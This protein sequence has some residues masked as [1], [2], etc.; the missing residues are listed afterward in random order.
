MDNKAKKQREEI[1]II[2]IGLK[3]SWARDLDQYWEIINNKICCTEDF[4]KYR[5]K[6]VEGLVNIFYKGDNNPRFYQG[7]YIGRI[8]EFDNEFFH[9]SP[10]EASLMDPVQRIFLETIRNT[11]D[12]AGYTATQLKQSKTGVFL[13]YT[14]SSLKDNYIVDIALNHRDLLAYSMTGNMA[15]LIPSRISHLLDLK[16]PTMVMDTAC[17]SAL[18]AVHEACEHILSGNCEMAV[19]GGIK[20]NVMPLILDDMSIGIESL[21]GKTRTFDRGA[22][23]SSMGEGCCTILLKPLHKAKEDGDIIYSIIKSSS[24]NHDG[25]ASG[26]TAPNPTAQS[27][28]MID[29]WNKANINPEDLQY[30]EAHGTATGLGD[31]IEIQGINKAFGKFTDKKQFCAIGASKSNLGHMYECSGLAALLKV[32]ASMRHNVI[33]AT[34][35]FLSPNINIDF[36]NSP[37]YINTETQEFIDNGKKYIAGVSAFGLSGTN[38]HVVLEKYIDDRKENIEAINKPT[39]ISITAKSEYSLTTKIT[40]YLDYINDNY[41]QLDYYN[42]CYNVNIYNDIYDRRIAFVVSSK[43]ELKDKLNY[44]YRNGLA[45]YEDKKIYYH[46]IERNNNDYK[47]RKAKAKEIDKLTDKVNQILQLEELNKNDLENACEYIILGAI[48]KWENIY[49]NYRGVHIPLPVYPF[50]R[51]RLWLPKKIYN[52]KKKLFYTKDF[53]MDHIVNINNTPEKTLIIAWEESKLNNMVQAVSEINNNV[54]TILL[55]NNYELVKHKKEIIDKLNKTSHIIYSPYECVTKNIDNLIKK[56]ENNLHTLLWLAKLISDNQL[57]VKLVCLS[58][59]SIG[60]NGE[61]KE[62][63]PENTTVLGLGKCISKELKKIHFCYLDYDDNTTMNYIIQEIN[64]KNK[65]DVVIYRNNIRYV[66]R[67][68]EIIPMKKDNAE[69]LNDSGVYIITG[70]LGGIGYETA[71]KICETTKDT[72]IIIIGRSDINISGNINDTQKKVL[73]KYNR[74]SILSNLAKNVEYYKGDISNYTR[75]EEII[76]TVRKKYGRIN[77][78]IHG[79]GIGGGKLIEDTTTLDIDT[80]LNPKVYGTWNLDQLTK[81]DNLDFFVLYSSIA[82]IFSSIE[83]S[84]YTAANTYLDYF[85]QYRNTHRKGRTYT[86]NWATW[87]EIGMS[88]EHNFTVDTLFKTI[89][90]KDGINGLFDILGCDYANVVIGELNFESQIAL[91]MCNYPMK[92]SDYIMDQ[93][94]LLKNKNKKNN[95]MN[96]SKVITGTTNSNYSDIEV[97]IAN[98]C[99]EVLGYEEIDIND[100]FF[101][102]GADSILMGHI[103]NIIVKHYPNQL[104][105]MDLFAY[106]SIRQLS[107]YI[108]S[109]QDVSSK[110]DKESKERVKNVPLHSGEK[111][112]AIIGIGLDFPCAKNIDD[113]WEMIINGVSVVRNIPK[114]R[115]KDVIKHFRYMGMKKEDIQF[116]KCAYLDEINKFDYEL[117]NMS[118]REAKLIDPVNRL[119]LQCSNSAIEDAGYGGMKIRGTNTGVFLGYTAN[120]GNLYSRFLYELDASL[121]GES[122][123]VNQVSMAASRIAYV[124]DLKGPT[125]IID[126]AC[127]SSLVAMHTACQQI[128]NGECD[129]ALVGGASITMSPLANGY[130]VG[131]ESNEEK[132]RSFSEGAMGTAVGEGIGAILLKPLSKALDDKDNIYG[133]IKGSSINQDGSSFGIAAPNY[134]AQSEVIQKAWLQAGIEPETINYIEAHGTGTALG[135]PIEVKGLTHAFNSLTDKKQFCALGTIK[136]N[137]GHLNEASGISGIIKVLLM[138]KY[139]KIPPTMFFQEP[140]QNIDFINSPLYVNATERDWK[141]ED[142]PRRAG[143]TGLGMSGT[144]CHIILE[145]PPEV[146]HE[147]ITEDTPNFFVISAKY[148]EGLKIIVQ[149]LLSWLNHNKDQNLYDVLY[150]LAM[151][152]GHY[153]HRVGFKVN[154]INELITSLQA[155]LNNDKLDTL[156]HEGKYAIV[157]ENK[158]NRQKYELTVEEHKMLNH[159]AE[160][161]LND[162][163]N[164]KNVHSGEELLEVYT[165]G[166]DI[167]WSRLFNRLGY[168]LHLPTYPYKREY[169][170]FSPPSDPDEIEDVNLDSFYYSMKW[171]REDYQETNLDYTQSGKTYLVFHSSYSAMHDI[172][173]L[174][175]ER[176]IN[177]IQVSLGEKFKKIDET[178]YEID[179]SY[180][181]LVQLFEAIKSHDIHKI[182][183]LASISEDTNASIRDEYK[184]EYIEKSLDNGFYHIINIIKSMIHTHYSK[185]LELIILSQCAYSINNKEKALYPENAVVLSIGKV[186]EQEYPNI[187]CRAID[188]QDIDD[189]PLVIDEIL[190]KDRR[191]YL[192]GFREGIRYV[193]YYT[194]ETVNPKNEI[195]RENGTYIITG[196]LGDIGIETAKYLSEKGCKN[197]ILFGRN[198]FHPKENWDLP[199]LSDR[200]KYKAS[201]LKEIEKN[202]VNILIYAVDISNYEGMKKVYQQIKDKVGNVHGVFHSAGV[203]GAGYILRKEREEFAQVLS[204][205][206][207]GTWIIDQ[208][209]K[210]DKLDFM[211]LYSSSVTFSGE[212]GQSDYV[213]ANSYLDAFTDYRNARGD[214]T[215]VINWVSWKETGMSVRYGINVD[216]ITK[217]IT[218]AQAIYYLDRLLQSEVRKVVIGQFNTNENLLVIVD[219]SR[220]RISEDMQE[221]IEQLKKIYMDRQK[222]DYILTEAGFEV[223]QVKKGKLLILPHSEKTKHLNTEDELNIDDK[224]ISNKLEDIQDNLCK[225]YSRILGYDEIDIYDNFFEMG[226]DSI[227]LTRMHEYIDSLYSDIVNVANLFEYT[228]IYTLSQFI[229]DELIKKTSIN[230]VKQQKGILS[231]YINLEWTG[232]LSH[233]Q[234]RIYVVYKRSRNK[235]IYNNPFAYKLDKMESKETYYYC[236]KTL[237]D[238]HEILRTSFYF[239]GKSICQKVEENIEPDITYYYKDNIEDINYNELLTEFDLGQAPLFKVKIIELGDGSCVMFFD[240]HHIIIDGY[241]SSIINK[242]LNDIVTYSPLR[243][244][245]YQYKHYIEYEK[246]FMKSPE[247]KKMEAY[248][249]DRLKDYEQISYLPELK[250]DVIQEHSGTFSL[251]LNQELMDNLKR[252][253]KENNTSLFSILLMGINLTIH[254]YDSCEDVIVG[255][256]CIGRVHED[257]MDIVGMF[258]N[259]LPMRNYPIADKKLSDFIIEIKQNI[260]NDLANQCYPYD[261]MVEKYRKSH[262]NGSSDLFNIMFDYESSNMDIVEGNRKGSGD[263]ILP[264]SFAKYDIDIQITNKN[265]SLVMKVDYSN[266]VNEEMVYRFINRYLTILERTTK[267]TGNEIISDI[268]SDLTEIKYITA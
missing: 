179:N 226:G 221:K 161:I 262:K 210:N 37:V 184:Y 154:S 108:D 258:T 79:A 190:S 76:T 24:I 95:V 251:T 30:I 110:R 49:S 102:M 1:A 29:A 234:K 93:L 12:D 3:I 46:V 237:M 109:K 43:E 35:N 244:I 87:S 223:A 25:T 80:M 40:N 249:N 170:W 186:I 124:N 231:K 89:K 255:V 22:N 158:K 183:H 38:C 16:G 225:I 136:P 214:R 5:A 23:G 159:K 247:Y 173:R 218:T 195:I 228:S 156:I 58:K 227:L 165:K 83:L 81:D 213:G 129:M 236:I 229:H 131:Y 201:V 59:N 167:D 200:D 243:D 175:T 268:I 68:K 55:D 69:L 116:N 197:I 96:K 248:W 104:Q 146:N 128:R 157:S 111:D 51:K 130:R 191:L 266:E 215:Y 203:A 142:T 134:L 166:A 163:I 120:L 217:A 100:N 94:A 28:V 264:V 168:H 127:S 212:A 84:A 232:E 85:C 261:K 86:I 253:A 113:Y 77:G 61:E 119:F 147:E 14:S 13:G 20:L 6:D 71:K 92:F 118:P 169:C 73:E 233:A 219:Y 36:I 141:R 75:L 245:T 10:K 192:V 187:E 117:F 115:S 252:V 176:E 18:I 160:T 242:E 235:K 90:T 181:S 150:T 209:T 137:I 78:V 143:I 9:L 99:Q 101:E 177:V 162:V 211:M 65:E 54:D 199:N 67:L 194:E 171:K 11:F 57:S 42:F 125:M 33:P 56:Q 44:I 182:L 164:N 122:L 63:N 257:V 205:K 193:E 132:T 222:G 238:R 82:T 64:S 207:Q 208:L 66:E 138:L 52:T 106:P 180:E 31:P 260:N 152:R 60:I 126:T 263:I 241:S 144:N 246:D 172:V 202:G 256:P 123:P 41:D 220:N 26:L 148:Q 48:P 250:E 34:I 206:V 91:M 88:V 27:E 17:S 103:F 4:P 145:E 174:L 2:G 107:E 105:L 72:T 155:Y 47:V 7:S 204:P 135:D 45:Q 198:G 74:L 21:D 224:N 53:E 230:E 149:N 151:G 50:Q 62:L 140:N 153:N 189:M 259:T 178:N 39:L 185:N 133:V 239:N 240:M 32:V 70:G 19:A 114:E 97:E 267:I 254:M 8:D 15:P 265:F 121:F 98:A 188:I 196:G 139:K 112:V 216:T